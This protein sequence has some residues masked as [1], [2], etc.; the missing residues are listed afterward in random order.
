MTYVHVR[1]AAAQKHQNRLLTNNNSRH[2]HSEARRNPDFT[3]GKGERRGYDKK[4]NKQA[5]EASSF[6]L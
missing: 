1:A 6:E 5:S 3:H 4:K 2:H